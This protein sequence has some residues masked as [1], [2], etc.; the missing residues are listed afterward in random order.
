MNEREKDAR[1]KG[2][3]NGWGGLVIIAIIVLINILEGAGTEVLGALLSLAVFVGVVMFVIK[4]LKKA[5]TKKPV[6][7]S[8]PVKQVRTVVRQETQPKAPERPVYTPTVVFDENAAATN[9]ERD[10]Q[11][12]VAQLQDFLKNGIIDKDEYKVLM[13]KY[14]KIQ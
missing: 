6:T 5:K 2:K 1:S 10:R 11:R 13:S 14:E 3:K 4:S 12:R 7:S 8:R 9:F